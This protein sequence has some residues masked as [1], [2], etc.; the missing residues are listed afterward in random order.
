MKQTRVALNLITPDYTF[1]LKQ[2]YCQMRV[3]GDVFSLLVASSSRLDAGIYSITAVNT[4]GSTEKSVQVSIVESSER[5][6]F[7]KPNSYV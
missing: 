5:F 6:A 1:G 7:F 3:D 2:I 4:A